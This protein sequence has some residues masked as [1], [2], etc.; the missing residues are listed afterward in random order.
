MIIYVWATHSYFFFPVL[1]GLTGSFLD[2]FLG[3]FLGPFFHV[4]IPNFGSF[5]GFN[6]CPPLV[7]SFLMFVTRCNPVWTTE[8]APPFSGPQLLVILLLAP[9][10]RPSVIVYELGEISLASHSFLSLGHFSD[11]QYTHFCFYLSLSVFCF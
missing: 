7:W 10:I 3:S 6:I 9:L 8:F 1:G 11:F 5:I 4:L 2:S